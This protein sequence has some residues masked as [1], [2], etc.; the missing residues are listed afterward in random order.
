MAGEIAKLDE[1]TSRWCSV[2]NAKGCSIVK[3]VARILAVQWVILCLCQHTSNFFQ[4][5]MNLDI[6]IT[7]RGYMLST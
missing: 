5:I 1:I 3:V 7:K 6:T 4:W 2:V